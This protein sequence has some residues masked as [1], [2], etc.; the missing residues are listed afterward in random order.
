MLQYV[1]KHFNRSVS[2]I[3][4]IRKILMLR[5]PNL[6]IITEIKG[7]EDISAVQGAQIFQKYLSIFK[8]N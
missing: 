3:Y 8:L 1:M 6:K 2:K 7:F 5:F 4:H